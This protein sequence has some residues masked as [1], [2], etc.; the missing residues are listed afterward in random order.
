MRLGMNMPLKDQAGRVLD[1]H[2]IVSRARMIEAAGFDGIWMQDWLNPGPRADSLAWLLV[3]GAATNHVEVGTCVL[4]VPL[5]NPVELA[6][7]F[8]TLTALTRGRFVAGVGAGSTRS[9]HDAVG[10]DFERRFSMLAEDLSIIRRLCRGEQV[11]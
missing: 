11:G 7:R 4:Q 1:G 5:R 3:A 8:L 2:G 9:N 10:I 6:S